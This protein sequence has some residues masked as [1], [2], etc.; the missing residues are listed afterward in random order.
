MAARAH[1]SDSYCPYLLVFFRVGRLSVPGK[2]RGVARNRNKCAVFVYDEDKSNY[3]EQKGCV[4]LA[5]LMEV[6]IFKPSPGQGV[7]ATPFP[8]RFYRYSSKTAARSAAK[9]DIAY[10][11]TFYTRPDILKSR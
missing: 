2:R 10:G 5:S 1:A 11:A 7:D 8:L 4:A 9:F 6:D 3:Q